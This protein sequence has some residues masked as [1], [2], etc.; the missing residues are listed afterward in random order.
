MMNAFAAIGIW[1]KPRSREKT[2]TGWLDA[3]KTLT[4]NSRPSDLLDPS[5]KALNKR[6]KRAFDWPSKDPVW[7]EN[8][9]K[10][11]LN[12]H[13]QSLDA[14]HE[15]HDFGTPCLIGRSN[16]GIFVVDTDPMGA[17]KS[18]GEQIRSILETIRKEQI[19]DRKKIWKAINEMKGSSKK[20]SEDSNKI[21]PCEL[22][23]SSKIHVREVMK[24]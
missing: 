23:E 12:D 13:K 15:T 10:C 16:D 24:K 17:E 4:S 7:L 1:L 22:S 5:G 8:L 18:E 20:T 19:T 6:H 2:K 9:N 21:E 14:S 11:G 3:W